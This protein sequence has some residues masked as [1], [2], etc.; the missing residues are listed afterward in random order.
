MSLCGST[1]SEDELQGVLIINYDIQTIDNV[2][3]QYRVVCLVN[4]ICNIC[5]WQWTC[6]IRNPDEMETQPMFDIPLLDE[7]AMQLANI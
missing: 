6:I 2:T 5:F 1:T 4:K 7:A 3:G